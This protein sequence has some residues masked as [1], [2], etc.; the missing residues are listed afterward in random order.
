TGRIGEL[1]GQL[2][3]TDEAMI[4]IVD[5]LSGTTVPARVSKDD[6][7]RILTEHGFPSI[8]DSTIG[9]A[10]MAA[11]SRGYGEMLPVAILMT[12]RGCA[13]P[14]VQDLVKKQFAG[15]PILSD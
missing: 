13:I 7:G 5:P 1:Y 9:R 11:R 3:A 10:R 12:G 6:V 15:V 2:V 8:L 14:V 4:G